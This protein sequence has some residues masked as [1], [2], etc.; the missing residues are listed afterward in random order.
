[1]EVNNIDDDTFSQDDTNSN[2]DNL[3]GRSEFKSKLLCLLYRQKSI[4]QNSNGKHEKDLLEGHYFSWSSQPQEPRSQNNYSKSN[5]EN[6]ASGHSTGV[7]SS[8]SRNYGATSQGHEPSSKGQSTRYFYSKD[9]KGPENVGSYQ[10]KPVE[11]HH[12]KHDLLKPYNSKRKHSFDLDPLNLE[13][14][15]CYVSG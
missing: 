1:M 11:Q 2:Y 5:K 13:N 4:C 12:Q 7:D 3:L 8:T 10:Q 14:E 9:Y 15:R 6:F